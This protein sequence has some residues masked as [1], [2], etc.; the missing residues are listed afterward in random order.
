MRTVFNY[1]GI[2]IQHMCV[3]QYNLRFQLRATRDILFQGKQAGFHRSIMTSSNGNIFHLQ[4]LCAGNPPVTSGFPHK[5]T[6]T[7]TFHRL[8]KQSYCTQF[9]APDLESVYIR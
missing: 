3:A 4:S 8:A 9:Q 2:F 5:G 1:D 6:E 7:Q